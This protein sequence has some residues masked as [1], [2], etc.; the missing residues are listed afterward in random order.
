[1][2]DQEVRLTV[3]QH[4]RLKTIETALEGRLTNRQAAHALAL[5]LRQVQRLKRKVH[6]DGPA[7]IR[8]GNTGRRPWNRLT[9]DLRER[10]LHLAATTYAGYNFSHL[11]DVLP[12]EQDIT[13]S[14]ETLRRLLRPA[15]FGR[16][17]RRR[18]AHRRRRQRR[19]REGELLFL[20]GSPHRWFGPDYP[21]AC[22]LLTSDDATGK[23]LAGRFQPQE[24]R[25]GC[26]AVCDRLFRTCGL[27]AAF[28]LDR[29]S[30]FIRTDHRAAKDG[31]PLPPTAF[32][33]AMHTLAVRL[34][35]A[36]SPQAR[37]RA[38]RLNGTFQDR[39]V[40]ELARYRI[41][42]CQ[43]A[44]RYLNERFIPRYVER[45]AHPAGDPTPAWRALDGSIDLDGILCVKSTR[46]VA[47]DNTVRY[48][49]VTYQL[50]PP[51]GRRHLVKAAIEVQQRF[52]KTIHFVHPG[53]GPLKAKPISRRKELNLL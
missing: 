20:D 23:P 15:G 38:E 17:M 21:M 24:D 5:S 9:D 41:H 8:H 27:P 11:A 6:R 52:D 36:N 16:P 33:I 47:N 48:G 39:L 1:V 35:F 44:T 7:G 28:Y 4:R 46:V 32:Q 45:F 34:I 40:A 50:E 18:K 25:D 22:L 26:F 19:Q 37:G 51:S 42:T 13:V 30:H 12:A 49:A 53:Y 29:A 3:A 31:R 2:S 14:D 43:R 10:I